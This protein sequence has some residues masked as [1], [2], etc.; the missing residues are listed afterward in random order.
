MPE[1]PEVETI[2]QDMLKKIKAK[3][4]HMVDLINEQTIKIPLPQ[5]FKKEVEGQTIQNIERKGKYLLVSLDSEK[6]LIFHL[7]LTGKLL[8]AV[9]GEKTPDYVRIVFN[10]SDES[11]L[12]FCDVRK[13]A[14]VYLL[15]HTELNRIKAIE[16]MGPDP[17]SPDFTL[18]KFK[19]RLVRRKGNIKSV[20]MDQEVLA[21]IGNI[22]SQ[23]ALYIA[24][25]HPERKTPCLSIHEIEAIYRALLD[26]LQE[27]VECRGSSVNTYLDLHGNK[28]EYGHRL[29]VYG[30]KSEHCYQCSALIERKKISGR[31]TYFC[32][33]CQK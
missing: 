7:K 14:E 27:A 23:E 20:L 1:L 16:N 18:E 33:N 9:A 24:G 28:G 19:E 10:F 8:F 6:L 29:K 32:N 11:K 26:V 21:G 25:I 3:K 30:R 22:Y 17:L 5:N 4:I 13:L 2:K 15:P 12:F 31:G